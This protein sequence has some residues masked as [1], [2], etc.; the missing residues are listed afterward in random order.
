M[1]YNLCWVH[2]AL[3]VTRNGSGRCKSSLEFGR[4]GGT[5][6]RTLRRL[7]EVVFLSVICR[8]SQNLRLIDVGI[9]TRES[10]WMRIGGI[11]IFAPDCVVYPGEHGRWFDC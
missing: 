7:Q 9:A 8:G 1:Y 5:I 11:V 10:K 2:Q 4:I 3:R 6:G